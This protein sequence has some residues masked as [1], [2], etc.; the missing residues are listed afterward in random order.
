MLR[1]LY[2]DNADHQV[3]GT[4]SET[5]MGSVS[6]TANTMGSTGTLM[7]VAAGSCTG[8]GGTKSIRLKFGASTL[9]L[10]TRA[11][12]STADWAMVVF[13]FNT[14]SNAQR[15]LQ[16]ATDNDVATLLGDYNSTAVDTTQ[17]QTLKLTGQ[18]SNAGDTITQAIY[19]VFIV[20][21]T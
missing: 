8:A 18:L 7:I 6:L 5:D 19:D 16:I 4:T 9:N 10:I 1:G 12:G 3:T 2:R 15:W 14:T 11:A 20:Q 17:N 13:L 21:L